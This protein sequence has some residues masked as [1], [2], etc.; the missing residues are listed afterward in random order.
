MSVRRI[1]KDVLVDWKEFG[2]PG[3]LIKRQ[4][5]IPLNTKSITVL[6]GVRRCG[7]TYLMFQLM[8]ELI[9]SG[10]DESDLLY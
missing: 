3:D 1:L 2:Y 4:Y 6:T 9:E 8:R 5:K 10:V 7:K